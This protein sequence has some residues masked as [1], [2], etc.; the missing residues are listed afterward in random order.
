MDYSRANCF[1][2]NPVNN[3]L[4][5][6]FGFRPSAAARPVSP[7]AHSISPVAAGNPVSRAMRKERSVAQERRDP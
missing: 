6:F 3:F 7:S 4:K 2:S 5:R 1:R